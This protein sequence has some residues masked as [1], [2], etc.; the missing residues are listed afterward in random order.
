MAYP[1]LFDPKFVD[2]G[3]KIAALGANDE[4]LADILG[5]S[6]RTLHAWKKSIPQFGD[7]LA[8]GKE[9]ADAE[10]ERVYVRAMQ[11]DTRA[12]RWWLQNRHPERFQ[13]VKARGR[14]LAGPSPYVEGYEDQTPPPDPRADA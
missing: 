5:V 4:E 14:T 6:I 3:R 13:A 1:T 9:S 7:A 11:G 10:V 8:E 12:A 2:M